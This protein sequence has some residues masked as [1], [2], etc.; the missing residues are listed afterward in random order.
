MTSKTF[1]VEEFSLRWNYA[2]PAYPP[3]DFNYESVLKT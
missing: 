1:L 3:Q 2:L